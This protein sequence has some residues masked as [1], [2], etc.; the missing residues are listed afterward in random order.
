MSCAYILCIYTDIIKIKKEIIYLE[1]DG[2]Q[3]R[4]GWKKGRALNI[5]KYFNQS[6]YIV[7]ININSKLF[8]VD[9]Y[10]AI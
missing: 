6:K 2:V 7:Q 9:F 8:S 3:E 5:L 10:N 1:S 4:V